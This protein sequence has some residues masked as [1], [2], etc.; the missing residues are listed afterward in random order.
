VKHEVQGERV[1]VDDHQYVFQKPLTELG[2]K[3]KMNRILQF[4]IYVNRRRDDQSE[5]V[6]LK[7]LSKD[8]D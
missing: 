7:E 3:Y 2:K 8:F 1:E 6:H 4:H 5:I